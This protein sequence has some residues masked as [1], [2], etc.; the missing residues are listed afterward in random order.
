M[1][2]SMDSCS[3]THQFKINLAETKNVGIM[4]S[5]SSEDI[6]AGGHLWRVDCYPR[7]GFMGSTGDHI[8]IFLRHLS[9]FKGARA[10]FE[11]FVMDGNGARSSAHRK[12]FVSIHTEKGGRRESAG[13][14]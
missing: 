12:S 14:R 8:A 2:A 3:F 9:E 6:F 11:A 5:V 10:S 13:W 4:H 1:S 7:G